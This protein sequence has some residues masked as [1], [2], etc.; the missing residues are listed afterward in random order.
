MKIVLTTTIVAILAIGLLGI[1]NN[2]SNNIH[3]IFAQEGFTTES[4]VNETIA[5]GNTSESFKVNDSS[6]TLEETTVPEQIVTNATLAFAQEG[7]ITPEGMNN[8]MSTENATE[9]TSNATLASVQ[10]EGGQDISGMTKRF[11]NDTT[12]IPEGQVDPDSKG[13]VDLGTGG[14]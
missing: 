2:N 6:V 11:E 12:G 8:T 13:E 5:L 14:S 9:W 7:A 4:L 3:Y 1:N 10:G